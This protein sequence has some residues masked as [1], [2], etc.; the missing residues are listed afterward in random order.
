MQMQHPKLEHNGDDDD[1]DG[2]GTDSIV[3]MVLPPPSPSQSQPLPQ[4]LRHTTKTVDYTTANATTTTLA[5]TR[6]GSGPGSYCPPCYRSNADRVPQSLLEILITAV[7]NSRVTKDTTDRPIAL[8]RYAEHHQI[9]YD[10]VQQAVA[11][12]ELFYE[13][14]KHK[15][16]KRGYQRN[17]NHK[18]KAQAQAQ[19]TTTKTTQG[20]KNIL[21]P[22][23]PTNT[24]NLPFSELAAPGVPYNPLISQEASRRDRRR[25][26]K[27]P[28]N[29]DAGPTI[30]YHHPHVISINFPPRSM[31]ALPLSTSTLG[32]V[33][34][35]GSGCGN[36]VAAT[37]A[38]CGANDAGQANLLRRWHAGI[39]E[40]V[41]V[42]SP[43]TWC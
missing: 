32:E 28:A 16:D 22:P 12:H 6:F 41:C 35:P 1:D 7:C 37:R 40:G 30:F 8:G 23:I 11:S 10:F 17:R 39:F 4:P 29:S 19:P 3:D 34:G 21:I 14:T 38:A 24:T 27:L 5:N 43:Q 9:S 15:N 18:K 20:I 25:Q 33:R 31:S 2:N 42:D 26:H 13:W 36:T